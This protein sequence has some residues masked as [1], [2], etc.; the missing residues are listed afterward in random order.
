MAP[1][2]VP[3]QPL[4]GDDGSA[5]TRAPVQYKIART[6]AAHAVKARPRAIPIR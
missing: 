5:G 6:P 2:Y 3:A 1:V 4:A